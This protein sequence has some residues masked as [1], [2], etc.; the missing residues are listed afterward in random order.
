[1]EI[2]PGYCAVILQ[3]YLDAGF[4]QPTL[5]DQAADGAGA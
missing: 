5:L 4:P 1:M 3:R 2:D